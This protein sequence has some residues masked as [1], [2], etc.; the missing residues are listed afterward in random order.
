MSKSSKLSST[1]E[2][3]LQVVDYYRFEISGV[4]R[5]GQSPRAAHVLWVAASPCSHLPS[6]AAITA[7]PR[8]SLQQTHGPPRAAKGL[9]TPLLKMVPWMLMRRIWDKGCIF[10]NTDKITLWMKN[11]LL[12]CACN[13][14]KFCH[15]ILSLLIFNG[16]IKG[17]PFSIK[18]ISGHTTF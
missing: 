14:F 5:W 6:Q 13:L 12:R 1:T 11:P 17:V 8:S 18:K 16:L 3:N 2:M 7:P 10:L 4:A 15:D 9:A